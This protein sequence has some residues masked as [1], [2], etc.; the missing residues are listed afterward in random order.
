MYY[1]KYC[2]IRILS[3]RKY[4]IRYPLRSTQRYTN[5]GDNTTSSLTTH[6]LKLLVPYSSSIVR[7]HY[8]ER[9]DRTQRRTHDASSLSPDLRT[10]AT[11]VEEDVL[12]VLLVRRAREIRRGERR[13]TAVHR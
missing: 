13:G 11:R 2:I 3:Y 5:Y 1:K 7:T 8:V 9:E 12:L 6:K 10:A 4:N